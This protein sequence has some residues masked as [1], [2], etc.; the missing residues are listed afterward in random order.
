[1]TDTENIIVSYLDS[2]LGNRNSKNP[3][4]DLDY[5]FTQWL[6]TQVHE[7]E[8]TSVN[9]IFTETQLREMTEV[10][11]PQIKGCFDFSFRASC[12]NHEIYSVLGYQIISNAIPIPH[13]INKILINNQAFYF[14]FISEVINREKVKDIAF[15]ASHEF[16]GEEVEYY[17]NTTDFPDRL[18]FVWFQKNIFP[19]QIIRP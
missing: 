10:L 4:T 8:L 12:Y 17:L 1:M 16:T 11:N 13:A 2:M 19:K 15:V 5:K 18:P 7:I 14:D 9:S 6:K 3:D